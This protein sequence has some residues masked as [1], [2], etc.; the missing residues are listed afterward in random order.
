ML[1]LI[2]IF[3]CSFALLFLSSFVG[4]KAAPK[5]KPPTASGTIARNKPSVTASF[6][7]LSN[8]KTV[9]YRLVYDTSNGKQGAGG[10]IKVGAKNKNLSRNV[11][12]GTCSKKVCTY[13]K[14][15]KNI[16]LT[17]D[18]TLKSGGA[19]SYVKKVK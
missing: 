11:L 8:V 19:V 16:T 14:N 4:I 5:S 13:H 2:S 12:L 6:S 1:K 3:L 7:N 17:V 9:K 15:V 18:F 10:T